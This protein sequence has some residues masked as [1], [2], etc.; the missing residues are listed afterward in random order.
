[1]EKTPTH[2]LLLGYLLK[3][4]PD[5]LFVAVDRNTQNVVRSYMFNSD[6]P[7]SLWG[8]ATRT[9]MVEVFRKI[10]H[11]YGSSIINIRYEDLRDRPEQTLRHLYGNLNLRIPGTSESRWP[12]NSSFNSTPAHVP[13]RFR[14]TV[15]LV[16]WIFKFVPG[17]LCE[18]IGLRHFRDR[19]NRVLPQWFFH[20]FKGRY[21]GVSR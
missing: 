16:S 3:T 5:A 6:D 4:F 20:V 7:Y 14:V 15:T 13:L 19:K 18:R 21:G 2:T 9:M 8:W 17:T 12:A 10:I 1:V 11:R